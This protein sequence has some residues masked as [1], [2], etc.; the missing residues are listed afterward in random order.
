MGYN[1]FRATVKHRGDMAIVAAALI[2]VVGLVL[3]AAF[4][5]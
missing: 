4:G 2:V 5:S 1:P 3:W